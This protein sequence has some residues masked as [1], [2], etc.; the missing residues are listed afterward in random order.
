MLLLISRKKRK[1]VSLE[2]TSE[3]VHDGGT[4]LKKLVDNVSEN[5]DVK[6]VIADGAYEIVKRILDISSITRLKLQSR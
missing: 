5:N 4:R 2:V 3:E 6:R 1:I